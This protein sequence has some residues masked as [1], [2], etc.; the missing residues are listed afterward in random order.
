MLSEKYAK[1]SELVSIPLTEAAAQKEKEQKESSDKTRYRSK[2]KGLRLSFI[3]LCST[4]K[5]NKGGILLKA[6]KWWFNLDR[7]NEN[8]VRLYRI[9]NNYCNN[10]NPLHG[11]QYFQQSFCEILTS[12]SNKQLLRLRSS[13]S[14]NKVNN[15]MKALRNYISDASDQE[16]DYNNF[17]LAIISQPVDSFEDYKIKVEKE[18]DNPW[19]NPKFQDEVKRV[20]ENED[21]NERNI[22]SASDNIK[23]LIEKYK[24]PF[25]LKKRN[26]STLFN[27]WGKVVQEID[28]QCQTRFGVRDIIIH[29]TYTLNQ[30]E[31]DKYDNVSRRNL[32]HVGEIVTNL[33]KKKCSSFTNE[34]W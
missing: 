28:Y 2:Y 32:K 15:F 25:E 23:S 16:D 24:Q 13:L 9:A 1:F 30:I 3:S 27:L 8:L 4:K 31:T 12:L 19:L 22:A 18:I 20:L 7:F 14:K 33:T 11:E 26:A 17:K 6:C 29:R 34:F 5:N 10:Q 21:Q